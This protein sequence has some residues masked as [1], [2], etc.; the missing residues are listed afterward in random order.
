MS[1]FRQHQADATQA[2]VQASL[3]EARLAPV[4]DEA[5]RRWS[6]VEDAALIEALRNVEL[7]IADL[8]G[9]ELG[10]YRD[11]VI[12]IDVM[13]HHPEELQV[14]K[15]GWDIFWDKKV[16]FHVWEDEREDSVPT[17]GYYYF[18]LPPPQH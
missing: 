7:K 8:G 11:G 1:P 2:G 16:D 17:P 6:L 4:V 10:E 3:D 14:Q 12:Y 18:E 9:L 13:Q 15:E 5:L